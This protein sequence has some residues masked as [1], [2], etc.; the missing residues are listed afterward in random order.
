M[1]YYYPL[2]LFSPIK[3]L[4]FV[5]HRGVAWHIQSPFFALLLLKSLTN[6]KTYIHQSLVRLKL[7]EER[8]VEKNIL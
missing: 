1:P 4:V 2:G 7:K 5:G 8:S 6:Q 3:P